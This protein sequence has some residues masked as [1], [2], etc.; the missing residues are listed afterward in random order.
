MN[1]RPT[2]TVKEGTPDCLTSMLFD[3]TRQ[4]LE[5]MPVGGLDEWINGVSELISRFPKAATQNAWI[6]LIARGLAAHER[7]KEGFVRSILIER[8]VTAGQAYLAWR[9]AHAPLPSQ[10]R[11]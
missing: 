1:D 2:D 10:E 8:V 6:S 5:S 7:Q 3:M 9:D 11:T 4:P